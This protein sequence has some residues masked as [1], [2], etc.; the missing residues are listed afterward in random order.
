[1]GK[2]NYRKIYSSQAVAYQRMIAAE[3]VDGNLLKAINSLAPVRARN[4]ADLGS[5]TGRLGRLLAPAARSFFAIDISREMLQEQKNQRTMSRAGWEI[6]QAD[7]RNLPVSSNW[8]NLVTAG[9]A[10]GHFCGWYP[11][12]WQ[13]QIGLVL[14]EM[15]RV[16]AAG[17]T[18]VVIETLG[19]GSLQPKPPGE[20]LEEYYAWLESSMGFRRVEIRT[21]YQFENVEQAVASTEFFFGPILAEAIRA[22]RWA[23]LPE[24]TGVWYKRV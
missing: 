12:E 4:V 19:T 7:M 8:A 14:N 2:I 5:G 23:R 9:W 6:A 10:I 16:C 13:K 3:D 21:D 11:M 24:W 22:N 15:R 17:G 1:M 20:H 18:L